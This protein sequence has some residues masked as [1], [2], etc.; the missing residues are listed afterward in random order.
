MTDIT[1]K[2]APGAS[3][4]LVTAAYNEEAYL[5]QTILSVSRQTILPEKWIIV[6]DGSTDQTDEIVRRYA[7]GCSFID[8]YRITEEH[9]RNFAAQVNAINTGISRLDR[10]AYDFIGNLDADITLEP[11]YFEAV[12]Q[13]FSRSSKLGLAGG[14]IYEEE[15]G[16]FRNRRG[17]TVTSVAHAVQLFRRECL[18]TLGGYKVFPGGGTDWHAQVFL[19][20][21]GWEVRA[22]PDLPAFHHRRTGGAF[23]LRYWSQNGKEDY[24]M[25]THPVIELFRMAKRFQEKPY[26]LGAIIRLAAFAWANVKSEERP[27]TDDFVRFLRRE[28]M[29]TLL[30]FLHWPNAVQGPKQEESN[31][32]H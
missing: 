10:S 12:L 23:G 13:K 20:M 29:Q 26:V 2:R 14:V 8:L 4:A 17:N 7:E 28:Q 9:P 5:E 25:G 11:T 18:S 6:S 24:Y 1:V 32:G 30:S 16:R 19:R 15:N 27:V 31:P 22:F 3:Y 21:K